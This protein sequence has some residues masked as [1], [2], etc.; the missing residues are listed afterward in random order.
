MGTLEGGGILRTKEDPGWCRGLVDVGGFIL[1][2]GGDS[3]GRRGP[4]K[5]KCVPRGQKGTLEGRGPS[6]EGGCGSPEG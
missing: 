6:P 2:R 1:E 5:A 3:R 4:V